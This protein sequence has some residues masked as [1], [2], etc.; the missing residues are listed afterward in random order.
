MQ[1][2]IIFFCNL[3][4]LP[5]PK[6][7]QIMLLQG[8]IKLMYRNIGMCTSLDAACLFAFKC[9]CEPYYIPIFNR[10]NFSSFIIKNNYIV[11]DSDFLCFWAHEDEKLIRIKFLKWCIDNV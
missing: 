8:A 4:K 5:L 7:M 2:I 10:T 6:K 3:F 1:R 11:K 9:L